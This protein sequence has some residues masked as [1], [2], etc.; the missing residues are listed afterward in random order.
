MQAPNLQ[1]ERAKRGSFQKCGS[2]GG[3]Q[4]RAELARGVGGAPQV[5]TFVG[6]GVRWRDRAH[7]DQREVK[8][9][10]CFGIAGWMRINCQRNREA[11]SGAKRW[12]MF[13]MGI[14]RGD[15]LKGY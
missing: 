3:R 5:L 1:C 6:T 14:R 12:A 9:S 11:S 10:D 2:Q 7:W 8:T 15:N 13:V 4:G